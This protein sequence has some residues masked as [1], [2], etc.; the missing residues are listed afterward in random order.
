M[1]KPSILFL[2]HEFDVSFEESIYLAVHFKQS[3][4][5]SGHKVSI[6]QGVSEKIDADILFSHI[7]ATT[8]AD[9]YLEYM[10]RF[11]VAIN[12]QVKDIS[13]DRFSTIMLQRG[14]RY[15]GPVIVKTKANYGGHQD[16]ALL[17]RAGIQ[18][19]EH[20]LHERPW[21]KVET[22]DPYDY[23]VFESI[24]AVPTGVGKT[25]S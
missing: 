4:E 18:P 15:T 12:G 3:W 16:L 24:S 20:D 25:Q 19:L 1:T 21:R 5:E 22:L 6:A 23:P 14:D 7:D 9:E 11:P 10:Q 2:Q 8:V 13:K 17:Q